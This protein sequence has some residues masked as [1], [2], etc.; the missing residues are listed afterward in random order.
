MK[1]ELTP[2]EKKEA[3]RSLTRMVLSIAFMFFLATWF[4]LLVIIA[5]FYTLDTIQAL[6]L[7][8]VTGILLKSFSDMWQFY[9]RK[10]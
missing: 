7:G 3:S 2:E 4:T 5:E 6:G 9:F 10:K 8:T 1:T